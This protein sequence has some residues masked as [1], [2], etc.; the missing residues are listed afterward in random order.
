[1]VISQ[2][3]TKVSIEKLTEIHTAT[4]SAR[5][6]RSVSAELGEEEDAKGEGS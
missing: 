3:Y 5:R 6:E 1:V 2:I 4:H